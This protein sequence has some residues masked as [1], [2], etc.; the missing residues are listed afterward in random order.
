MVIIFVCVYDFI[1]QYHDIILYRGD[2][3]TPAP[4]GGKG[5]CDIRVTCNMHY[6][7]A[8]YKYS[9]SIGIYIYIYSTRMVFSFNGRTTIESVLHSNNFHQ[10]PHF[11]NIYNIIIIYC[12]GF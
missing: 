1:P 4:D 3:D 5:F 9:P 10:I 7:I 12:K 11:E 6:N 8:S 2:L